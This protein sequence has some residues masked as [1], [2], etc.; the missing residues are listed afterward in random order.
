VGIGEIACAMPLL[1]FGMG[2]AACA[3][4]GTQPGRVW[5]MA[6]S[7]GLA[8]FV[9]CIALVVLWALG[10][11][12]PAGGMFRIDLAAAVMLLLV[13]FLGIVILRF[14]RRYLQGEARQHFYASAL[15]AT[16]AAVMAIVVS[17]DLT[18]IIAAWFGGSLALHRLLTF[19]PRRTAALIAAHKKFLVSRIAELCFIGAAVLLYAQFGTLRID[20]LAWKLAEMHTALPWP[21]PLA[22]V[23]L[24]L[25]VALKT[26][27][28]PA[29]GWLIQVM[30]APTPVSALLHAGV[31]NLGPDPGRR[32]AQLPPHQ[33]PDR[34]ARR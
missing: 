29:H 4:L 34:E 24:V 3:R 21:V 6:W 14:S 9:A 13:S 8:A 17:N 27:Q 32:T 2:S 26:A 19:Y 25:G 1:I 7:A 30:E 28:I 5:R 20:T 16:L 23:L 31:V 18:L 12:S 33:G 15:L 22:T 10:M 11:A